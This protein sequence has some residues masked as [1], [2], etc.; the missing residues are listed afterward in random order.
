MR[1]GRIKA[2]Q[3]HAIGYYHCVSRVA[4]Q[5]FRFGDAEK[6]R[7]LELMREYEAFCQVNVLTHAVME[8]HVHLLVAVPRR[9][10]V[11][12]SDKELLASVERLTCMGGGA[13]IRQRLEAFRKA[14]DDR[15]AEELREQIFRRMWDVS[16][17]MKALKQRFTQWYK[18]VHEHHGT[19]WEGRFR[20]VV[21]EGAG[22]ILAGMAA[23]IDL[24]SQ[25][26]GAYAD[27]AED[28]WCGYA[29]ALGGNKK[30]LEGLTHIVAALLGVTV[31]QVD[32]KEVLPCYRKWLYGRGQEKP[33]P[34]GKSMR[35]GFTP[36]EVALIRE[37]QGA[38]PWEDYIRH[39]V[40]YL[41]YGVILGTR[42]FVNE[43]YETIQTGVRGKRREGAR[44]MRGLGPEKFY[45]LRALRVRLFGSSGKKPGKGLSKSGPQ[46]KP[47]DSG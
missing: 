14:G 33:G 39:R 27:P 36:E 3:G 22:R 9:P 20:S 4:F 12:P 1:Q 30:A 47:E 18:G 43:L 24:N 37:T 25:R 2:P 31:D 10:K 42:G 26:A 44:R 41:S 16:A 23:Y 38:V 32:P 5:L 46:P 15:S 21:V 35:L 17:F 7:F 11:L 34:E 8:N 6:D 13:S 19:F 29:Q 40:R 28:R 45:V